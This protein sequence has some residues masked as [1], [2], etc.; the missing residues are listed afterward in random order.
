MTL[1]SGTP[2]DV[3]RF[4]AWKDSRGK[5]QVHAT[6]CPNLGKHNVP[7]C[8]CP[9]RLSFATVDSYIGKLRAVF[10]DAG[11]EATGKALFALGNPA[12]PTAVQNYLKAFSSEQLQASVT[13]KHA[14]PLFLSKLFDVSS[15]SVREKGLLWVSLLPN[16]SFMRETPPCLRRCFSAVTEQMILL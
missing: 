10:K 16:S 12:A 1:F 6:S 3:C 11:R 2:K 8:G 4:L 15:S 13:P 14:S 5:T 9:T 7:D